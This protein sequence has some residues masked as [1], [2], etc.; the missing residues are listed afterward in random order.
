MT[1]NKCFKEEGFTI[2]ELL[3]VLSIASILTL[4]IIPIGG[5]WIK[6]ESDE[7]ALDLFI[8]TIHSMQSY[9]L[10]NEEM[11]SVVLKPT[12]NNEFYY[13][14]LIG[15]NQSVS[16]T[17]FPKGMRKSPSSPLQRIDFQYNGNIA[18][19]GTMTL[20]T[21]Y[22]TYRLTFQ[23]VKGR[24]IVH[25][26]DRTIVARDGFDASSTRHHLWYTFT[27][28]DENDDNLT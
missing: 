16:K 14:A 10:A 3:L 19:P 6:T 8:T 17:L 12:G 23:F 26:S 22:K 25:E 28:R 27:T 13:E 5:K 9:A 20:L 1:M 4:T 24:V 15:G 7:K 18:T 11:T 21:D 2:L